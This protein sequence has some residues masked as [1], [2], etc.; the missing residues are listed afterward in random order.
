MHPPGQPSADAQEG[1]TTTDGD[2]VVKRMADR[3]CAAMADEPTPPGSMAKTAGRQRWRPLLGLTPGA[4]RQRQEW[5]WL[6]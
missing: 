4:A 5:Q 1:A 2:T 6:K 3:L